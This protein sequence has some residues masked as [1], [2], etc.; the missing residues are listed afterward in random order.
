MAT[1]N[2]TKYIGEVA[3]AFVEAKLKMSDLT[4]A[5][6]IISFLHQRYVEMSANLLETWQKTLVVKKDEKIANPSKLRVDLR[7]YADLI[8]VGVFTLKE[9]LPLLG[10]V[11]T[12]LINMDKEEHAHVALITSFCKFCG[13]DFAGLV[14][15]RMRELADKHSYEIPQSSLLPSE[16]Q[17]NVKQLLSDYYASVGKHLQTDFIDLQNMEKTNR[18][19]LLTK[20]EVHADRLEKTEAAKL[21]YG[22]LLANTEQLSDVLDEEMP[23]LKVVKKT[24]EDEEEEAALEDVE[25][26]ISTLGSLWEDEDSRAFYESLADLK[27]FIPAIL[28]RD[29]SKQGVMEEEKEDDLADEDI[30]EDFEAPLEDTNE[31]VAPPNI[32]EDVEEIDN[33]NA[34]AKLAFDA[35]LAKLPTCVSREMIDNAAAEFCMNHNTKNNR[36]KLVK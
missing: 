31:D 23:E 25:M 35:F 8:S 30:E 18:R 26:E 15:K 14:P 22:K 11:L 3:S 28:Y 13:D 16:K 27:A 10:Q 9:G 19:I 34:S 5:I 29:S 20:G 6:E 17:K 2:L 21:A 36:K 4:S 7:F 33:Q 24:E 12:V 32:E 1:L